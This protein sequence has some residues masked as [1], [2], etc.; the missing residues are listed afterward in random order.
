MLAR[1]LYVSSQTSPL[2]LRQDH[3]EW[4]ALSF[5]GFQRASLL[6]GDGSRWPE[7]LGRS[8]FRRLGIR[9]GFA[10]ARP[11]IPSQA[12]SKVPMCRGR[13]RHWNL[14]YV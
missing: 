3:K 6:Y 4:S 9:D 8:E 11:L 14:T 2:H 10:M 7:A 12:Y 5:E 13:C 1:R